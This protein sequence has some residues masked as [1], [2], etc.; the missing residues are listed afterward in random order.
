MFL[1]DQSCPLKQIRQS[2]RSSESS[3]KHWFNDH[4]ANLKNLVALA[5]D[6]S[7][8]RGT[9][10]VKKCYLDLRDRYKG[11]DNIAKLEFNARNI[12]QAGDNFSAAWSVIRK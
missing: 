8:A 7:K 9:N 6:L 1:F 10:D 4:L 12:E 5:Y 3:N 2:N 11:A